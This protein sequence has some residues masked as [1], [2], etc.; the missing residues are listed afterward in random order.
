MVKVPGMVIKEEPPLFDSNYSPYDEPSGDMIGYIRED[1]YGIEGVVNID[2]T[3]HSK[4]FDE[5]EDAARWIADRIERFRH[6]LD[7]NP[8]PG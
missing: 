1:E 5:A 2:D 8:L 7:Y 3:K 4:R 6:G